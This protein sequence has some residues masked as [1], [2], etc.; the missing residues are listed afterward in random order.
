MTRQERKVK[1]HV[2]VNLFMCG[3]KDNLK[4]ST[5]ETIVGNRRFIEGM[6]AG[7]NYTGIITDKERVDWLQDIYKGFEH[8]EFEKEIEIMRR[9]QAWKARMARFDSLPCI[10]AIKFI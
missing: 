5:T 8:M 6:I 9:K 1:A 2:A 4:D 10:E 7:F 3:Y